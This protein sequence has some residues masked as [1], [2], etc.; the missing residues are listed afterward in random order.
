M[1]YD[2]YMSGGGKNYRY[3]IKYNG[4][5]DLEMMKTL[6]ISFIYSLDIKRYDELY[7]GQFHKQEADF[8]EILTA[9][10]DML[11]PWK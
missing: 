7:Y 6:I 9:I 10:V 3:E 8:E 1:N 11:S 2:N 5:N 4:M